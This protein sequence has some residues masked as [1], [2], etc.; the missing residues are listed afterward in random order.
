M[1]NQYGY[2]PNQGGGGYQMN[3]GYDQQQGRGSQQSWATGYQGSEYGGD[4]GKK[5]SILVRHNAEIK[6]YGTLVCFLFVVFWFFSDG[7]FSFL[8]TLASIVSMSSFLM[9]ALAIE[10]TKSAKG[11]SLKM[12]E[13][14]LVLITA[15][16]FAIIPFEGYLPYDRSGDWLY[17]LIEAFQFCLAGTIVFLCRQ[18]YSGTYNPHSDTLNHFF[19]MAGAAVLA[20]IFHPSLNAF[21]PSDMA[22]AFALYLESVSSL[23]QLFM[24]QREKEVEK[25]TAHFLAM[26]ALSKLTSFIFWISSFSELSDPNHSVKWSV[27]Y[28]VIA[29][30]GFQ[31]VV[32]GDFIFQY[33][34]C[35]RTGAPIQTMLISDAV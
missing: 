2:N 33:I 5:E 24:F 28:W 30:Q 22:W 9:V 13:S 29:M 12:M 23:P 1:Q 8:L 21:M 34:K 26:Q 18:R 15:R 17:Q 19:L 14:Y 6:T 7:D 27:G 10:S 32:M 35:I 16:L 11:I 3:G 25:W 20:L 4:K 31:L